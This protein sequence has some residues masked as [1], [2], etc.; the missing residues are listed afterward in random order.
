MLAYFFPI[1]E[2]PCVAPAESRYRPTISP[3]SLIPVASVPLDLGKLIVV[4]LPLAYENAI[5]VP[6]L[7]LVHHP[8]AVPALLTP[9]KDIPPVPLMASQLELLTVVSLVPVRIIPCCTLFEST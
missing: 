9:K 3:L 1:F 5:S 8:T 2:K 4:N 6:V 7:E